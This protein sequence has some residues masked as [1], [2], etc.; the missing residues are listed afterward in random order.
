MRVIALPGEN[1]GD[2]QDH[3]GLAS[4]HVFTIAQTPGGAL[5]F[6]TDHGVSR[7]DGQSWTTLTTADGLASNSVVDIVVAPDGSLWFGTSG[8]ASHF[9]GTL[10]ILHYP[11]WVS[12]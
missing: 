5:W 8:G 11:G 4:N 7:F 12:Q 9:D 1:G 10:E 6:G 2:R 3:D